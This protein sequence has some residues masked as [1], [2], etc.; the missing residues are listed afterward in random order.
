[1]EKEIQRAFSSWS[2]IFSLMKFQSLAFLKEMNQKTGRG[3]D[4]EEELF[5]QYQESFLV[6]GSH[7][8]MI[9]K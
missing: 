4:F 2:E 3:K 6:S 9:W 5:F 8:E 1:L 7:S